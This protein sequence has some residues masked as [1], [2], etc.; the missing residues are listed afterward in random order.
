MIDAMGRK[1]DY[2]RV[3]ITDRCN[4][5]CRYC[6]PRG[7]KAVAHENILR[8]EEIERLV[9][10]FSALGVSCVRVTGG[11]PF[12]RKGAMDL[13]KRLRRVRG[14]ER[15]TVTTNGVELMA[16]IGDLRALPI[17]GINL[18]LDTLDRA[19]YRALTGRDELQTVL[20]ALYA[21]MDAG[22]AA[23][24]NCVPIRGI[25]DGGVQ[26]LAG[27]AEKYPIDVRFIELMPMGPGAALRGVP[28]EEVLGRVRERYAD[29]EEDKGADGAGPA[30]YYASARLL[31]RIGFINALSHKFCADCN[32]LRLT[33]TGYLKLCLGQEDGLDLA[34]LLHSGAN[35]QEIALAIERA[36]WSK[37][38]CHAFEGA[39]KLG[40]MS[41]IGG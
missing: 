1:I 28:G 21:M 24:V 32:R 17:D 13:I 15:L 6:M 40:G 14:V 36:V 3:S 16:F 33:S 7:V 39:H 12:A 31:G 30:R 38:A 26:A 22:I 29:L 10:I 34:D 25:N 8:F 18:S 27:L 37:P 20:S 19:V 5:R 4:L 23:K 9:H 11:E 35:D 2:L 41:G